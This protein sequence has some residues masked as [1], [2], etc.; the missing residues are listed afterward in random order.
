MDGFETASAHQA[1]AS[2]PG[3]SRSSSS[4]RPTGDAQLAFRGYAAGAVDY[5]TKPFDPW[6]LRAKV[7]VFVDL[8]LL[9]SQVTQRAAER[10]ALRKSVDEALRLLDAAEPTDAPTSALL[11]RLRGVLGAQRHDLDS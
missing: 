3:T 11:A 7:S 1:A 10:D 6:V 8:Y 4:P 5:L 9:H 2:G